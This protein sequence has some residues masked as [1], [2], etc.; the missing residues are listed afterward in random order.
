MG[1]LTGLL[2]IIA[3]AL[4]SLGGW[5]THVYICITNEW[6]LFLVAGAIAFPIALVHGWGNWCD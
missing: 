1:N 6:F 5:I 4:A 2:I 3:V